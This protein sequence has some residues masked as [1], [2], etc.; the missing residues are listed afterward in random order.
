MFRATIDSRLEEGA[1]G[2]REL[3]SGE[4]E[5]EYREGRKIERK[6]G[7]KIDKV[8]RNGVVFGLPSDARI[9]TR[10]VNLRLIARFTGLAPSNRLSEG[11]ANADVRPCNLRSSGR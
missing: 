6:E 7:R 8:G 9:V 11:C 2:I 5:D 10:G 4:S 1:R 3:E